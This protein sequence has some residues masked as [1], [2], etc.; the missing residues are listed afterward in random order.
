MNKGQRL[1]VEVSAQDVEFIY[2]D[3]R[4]RWRSDEWNDAVAML[5]GVPF[6]GLQTSHLIFRSLALQGYKVVLD[7]SYEGMYDAEEGIPSIVVHLPDVTDLKN[8]GRLLRRCG[9][10]VPFEEYRNAVVL[11][12]SEDKWT[13]PDEIA[14][15]DA[16]NFSMHFVVPEKK[17]LKP[18]IEIKYKDCV[19]EKIYESNPDFEIWRERL[20]RGIRRATFARRESRREGDAYYWRVLLMF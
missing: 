3:G 14:G 8:W 18:R 11:A 2:P 1:R 15:K 19:L 13:Y 9:E 4:V 20:E 6:G 16:S 7:A 12:I 17:S 10:F 5:D